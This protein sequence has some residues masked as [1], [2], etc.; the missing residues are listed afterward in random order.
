MSGAIFLSASVPDPKRAL[1]YAQSASS[2]SITAAVAALLYVT[3]GRRKIVWG[4]HPAIT[5]MVWAA[6]ESFNV[7]YG[8]WVTLFQSRFFEDQFPEDNEKFRNVRYTDRIGGRDASL[9]L[10]RREM[11]ESTDFRAGVFIGGME[12]I[13]DEYRLFSKLQPKAAVIPVHSTGGAVLDI[14]VDSSWSDELK[15]ELDYVRLFHR[16]L[17]VDISEIRYRTPKEQPNDIAARLWRPS[18]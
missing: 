15:L 1:K 16:Y 17:G 3:L 10:M 11:L 12:G 2:V 5:P 14:P 9:S 13:I 6:C 4:G 18:K 8:Q 7:D